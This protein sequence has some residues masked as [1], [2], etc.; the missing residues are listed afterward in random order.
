MEIV[1][2]G[3]NFDIKR[4]LI[5]IIG[6]FALIY[7]C[8]DLKRDNALD[9]KNP[10]A[11]MELKI[12][13]E[14]FVNDSTGFPYSAIA[15]NALTEIDGM[16]NLSDELLVLE[17]HV[18]HESWNDPLEAPGCLDRYH[19]YVPQPEQRGIPD[20]FFNGRSRRVQG[21]TSEKVRERYLAAMTSL[22]DQRSRFR[23]VGDKVI[24][25]NQVQLDLQIARMGKQSENDL[26]VQVVIAED[27]TNVG[28]NLVVRK[29]LSPVIF[30]KIDGGEVKSLSFH[31]AVS[32]VKDQSNLFAVVMI[33]KS[34]ESLEILQV[35]KF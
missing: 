30:S 31:E 34:D 21:A 24:A 23:L 17:Y 20:V 25:D 8:A 19:K 10:Q 18:E 7:S 26:I 33:Q 22:F 11:T 1:V 13:A 27:L 6:I 3:M 32:D 28:H 16:E 5:L 29:I 35:E 15:L 12:V 9:P 4:M 2:R 14:A